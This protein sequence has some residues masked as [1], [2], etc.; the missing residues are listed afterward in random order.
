MSSLEQEI[1]THLRQLDVPRQQ[2]VL[3]LIRRLN[4]PSAVQGA[5]LVRFVGRIPA[6]DLARMEVAI[7][8]CEQIDPNGW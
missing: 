8:D 2:Q 4:R 7:A 6:D 3:D 1:I 5:D